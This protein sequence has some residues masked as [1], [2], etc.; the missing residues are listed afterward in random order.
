MRASASRS[1]RAVS[2][3]LDV[4]RERAAG[5]IE[6]GL[7]AVGELAERGRERA[8]L[9]GDAEVA[10]L[11]LREAEHVR[12]HAPEPRRLLAHPARVVD[13]ASPGSPRPSASMSP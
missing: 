12:H 2:V 5:A 8:G 10:A 3:G 11:E 9:R 4:E 7:G 1:K 13:A 6:R